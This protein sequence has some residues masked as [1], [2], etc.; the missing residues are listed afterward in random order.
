M[1]VERAWV[2]PVRL[3]TATGGGPLSPTMMRREW[4][5][6]LI[7]HDQAES[8]RTYG[9]R[10]LHAE[11]I[12]G[13]D[14]RVSERLFW[15]L[16]H[17]A[18]LYGLTGPVEA[19]MDTGIPRSDDLVENCFARSRLIESWIK[20]TTEHPMREGKV[21]CCCFMNTC[22]SRIVRWSID[23]V[24]D[25]QLVIN[26]LDMAINQHTVRTGAIVDADRGVQFTSWELTDKVC[27]AGCM[28]SFGSVGD[29]LENAMM[30]SFWSSMQNELLD[31]TRWTT[32]IELPNAM[33]NCIEVFYSHRRRHSKLGY[34]SPI[35][36][37]RTL[38]QETA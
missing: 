15:R 27:S 16:M 21:Y 11:L 17:D 8:R 38:D 20:D 31:R 26:A 18:G 32:R 34:V 36:D 3:T 2:S 1:P 35:E 9:S 14:I 13:R 6:A 4:L 29:A 22:S 33:F 23:T 24:Q 12:E 25:S 10:R 37:E 7:R 28:T 19:L 30:E 5:T